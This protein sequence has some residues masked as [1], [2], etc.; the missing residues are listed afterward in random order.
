MLNTIHDLYIS[1]EFKKV[2]AL[3]MNERTGADGFLR[4]EYC[5]K[6]IVKAYD[7]IAHHKTEVTMSNLNDRNITLNPDNI[8][9]VHH[10]CHNVIHN[11]FGRVIQKVYV[12]YGA[13]RSGKTTY[14]NAIKNKND[15]IVDIDAIW[16]SIGDTELNKPRGLL[17]I[18]F[19]IRDKL[20]QDILTRLGK[21]D[22]AYIITT[23][24]DARLIDKLGAEIIFIPATRED[25]LN[26]CDKAQWIE[27]V[28]NWFDNPPLP[29]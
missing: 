6:P 5:H 26:R 25:C 3:L 16:I 2:R 21:W 22:N 12:V 11:R 29:S 10:Q 1:P 7:C 23:R 19:G 27:Y 24:P 9:L 4:C 17:P 8:M 13:P 28:N 15:I 18:V 14:V 20:Y